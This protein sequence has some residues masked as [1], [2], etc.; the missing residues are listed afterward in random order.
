MK[1]YMYIIC[2]DILC[3]SYG[4][5]FLPSELVMINAVT[6]EVINYR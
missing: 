1:R 4:V 2:R 3:K 5:Y 6:G